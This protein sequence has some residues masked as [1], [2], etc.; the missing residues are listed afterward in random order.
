MA[1]METG[2]ALAP[3]TTNCRLAN[4]RM[5]AAILLKS[6][7]TK[8]SIADKLSIPSDFGNLMPDTRIEVIEPEEGRSA[9]SD[10]RNSVKIFRSDGSIVD[11]QNKRN[12]YISKKGE[13]WLKD[14]SK[15]NVQAMQKFDEIREEFPALQELVIQ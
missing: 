2:N 7:E 14:G 13:L 11:L 15:W 9:E 4:A 5:F 3:S 10:P 6:G 8:E 12:S 1:L